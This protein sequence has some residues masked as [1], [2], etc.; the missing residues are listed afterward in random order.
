[1]YTSTKAA[2]AGLADV[3]TSVD[4]M[5]SVLNAYGKTVEQMVHVSD[6]MFQAIIRGKF[7]Y[8]DLANALGYVTPIAAQVGV[9]F[10]EL[11]AAMATATR[12]GQHIDM[13]SRGLALAMQN[14]IKP[15]AQAK[16]VA[17]E[18][19]I[20]L[21]LASLRAKGLVGFLQELNEKTNGNAAVVSQI[22]PNMRSYRVAMVLA[23]EGIKGV[24]EDITLM[25]ESLGKS[26]EAFGKM[27][28]TSEMAT[29][30]IE[31]TFQDVNRT[32][33]ESTIGADLF[34][35]KLGVIKN[36]FVAGFFKNIQEP[37]KIPMVI[38]G[39]NLLKTIMETSD[40]SEMVFSHMNDLITS[41][42]EDWKKQFE[43]SV[44]EAP[45]TLF[46]KMS[47]GTAGNL[48][49]YENAA[50]EY[51]AAANKWSEAKAQFESEKMAG[52]L[53]QGEIF[54]REL[55][56]KKEYQTVM[57]LYDAYSYWKAGVDDAES[58]IKEHSKSLDI[59]NQKLSQLQDSIGEVGVLYDGQLGVQLELAEKEKM[60][61]DM[62]HYV[63]LALE[64]EVYQTEMAG[65]NFNWYSSELGDAITTVR[66]YE[67]AQKDATQAQEEFNFALAKNKIAMMELQ[68]IG[69]MRRR[70]LTRTEQKKMKALQIERTEMNIAEAKRELEAKK[71]TNEEFVD[72]TEMAYQEAKSIIESFRR[73]HNHELWLMKEGADTTITDIKNQIATNEQA[74][75][76]LSSTV[77]TTHSDMVDAVQIYAD[78][79]HSYY[80]EV[81]PNDIQNYID[82]LWEAV[83]AQK[84][85]A[86]Q[87]TSSGGGGGKV[88]IGTGTKY[89]AKTSTGETVDVSGGGAVGDMIGRGEIRK[90]FGFKRGIRF[91]PNDMYAQVHRGESIVP[92]GSNK[93]DSIGGGDTIV[94]DV[95]DNIVQD[96]ADEDRLAK[97]IAAAQSKRLMSRKTGKSNYKVR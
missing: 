4:V 21:S 97:K 67:Q 55:L 86:Q 36:I 32:I 30:I 79:A 56:L 9:S 69:M 23:G 59:Y 88:G 65:K 96:E 28:K 83:D 37:R 3:S 53:D 51:L 57:D 92:P 18:Y 24:E 7:R 16:K 22:I 46:T 94:I 15:G 63:S 12:H 91:V 20:E 82:L 64:E 34:L 68:L 27:A 43:E 42:T 39:G 73:A 58:A 5:T 77:A 13:V 85:A 38:P 29:N 61:G 66:Q 25:S 45:E 35:K 14:I 48:D 71:D 41:Y 90:A 78:L 81:L 95:H 8:E 52:V 74:Y 19:G 89:K 47:E 17:A 50:N 10:E 62:S 84:A 1:L 80:G 54:E 2:V 60:V 6:V 31:Q 72:D 40:Q 87:S 44:A 76:D 33:G 26:D 93:S 49:Q 11:S 75:L 70:G